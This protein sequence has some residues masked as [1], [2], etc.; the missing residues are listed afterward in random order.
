MNLSR[1]ISKPN[2]LTV[3]F[4]C[5][6]FSVAMM[7]QVKTETTTTQGQP[8]TETQV[9]RGEV[10]SVNGNDL[11]VKMEN[12]EVRHFPNVPDSAKVTV[13]GKELTVHE[14]Q[15]GMKLERTISTT[16]T[17]Q[18][19]KTVHKVTGRV[20]R[21]FPPKS[22]ILTLEDGTNQ[23]F[24]IPEGQKFNIEGQQTDAFGLRQGMKITATKIVEEP[25]NVVAQERKVVGHAPA[26]PTEQIQGPILIV[27]PMAAA[28]PTEVAQAQPAEQAQPAQEKQAKKLPQTAGEL[29][30]IGLLGALG[31]LSG[32]AL[33]TLSR[34]SLFR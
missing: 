33:Y 31:L 24:N 18:T 15:P 16:T 27:V 10:V 19:V 23:Q 20:F 1:L 2:L 6:I 25:V 11:I 30:L 4:V 28:Q 13:D 32:A 34:R 12:G 8:T 5:L 9:E 7:A 3:G 14:L 22:V 26:P 21:V 17:P 29:P